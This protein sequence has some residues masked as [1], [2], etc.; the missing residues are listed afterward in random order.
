[1]HRGIV[2]AILLLVCNQIAEKKFDANT[3]AEVVGLSVVRAAI[4]AIKPKNIMGFGGMV[5]NSLFHDRPFE[6]VRRKG[7]TAIKNLLMDFPD[8][9]EKRLTTGDNYLSDLFSWPTP[10]MMVVGS[11]C[12]QPNPRSIIWVSR[13]S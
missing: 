12:I 11:P 3:F 4:G 1:M 10:I 5:C 7:G 8:G 9:V 2:M 6:S 13:Y